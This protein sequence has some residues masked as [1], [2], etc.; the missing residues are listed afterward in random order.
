[1]ARWRS[2][3]S[4]KSEAF[5]MA[6]CRWVRWK[7]KKLLYVMKE[8]KSSPENEEEGWGWGLEERAGSLEQLL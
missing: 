1:M 4:C 5:E 6:V 2:T 3:S 8:V 7:P